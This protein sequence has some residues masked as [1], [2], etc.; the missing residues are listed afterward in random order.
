MDSRACLSRPRMHAG[1]VFWLP[2]QH[3]FWAGLLTMQWANTDGAVR[4]VLCSPHW[5]GNW[6]GSWARYQTTDATLQT[7]TLADSS[8]I[9]HDPSVI[10]LDAASGAMFN[11]VPNAAPGGPT[12]MIN[13]ATGQVN[14]ALQ[15]VW[16]SLSVT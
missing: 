4:A 9:Q 1:C 5:T 7:W 13:G 12:H 6:G 3:V 10:H 2:L 16:A 15:V 8:F 11:P 14:R